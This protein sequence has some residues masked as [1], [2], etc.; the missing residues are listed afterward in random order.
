[1]GDSPVPVGDAPTGMKRAQFDKIAA[2]FDFMRVIHFV[3]RVAG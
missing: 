2:Q 3:R 1:M